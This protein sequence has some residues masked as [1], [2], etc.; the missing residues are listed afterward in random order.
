[1]SE[2]LR[3]KSMKVSNVKGITEVDLALDES[4]TLLTGLNGAGTT[5]VIQALV[6]AVTSTWREKPSARRYPLF[7]FPANVLRTGTSA[8]DIELEVAFAGRPPI[9]TGHT[10]RERDLQMHT[11]SGHEASEYLKNPPGP[12]PLVVY[13]E[14][15]RW[16]KGD[17]RDNHD[18]SLSAKTNRETAL[19]AT[20]SALR[21]LKRWF[22]EKEAKEQRDAR[23]RQ[24]P[25]YEDPEL[26]TI[27]GLLTQLD[28]FTAIRSRNKTDSERLMLVVEKEGIDIPFDS[29][30]G[31]EEA[32]FVLSADL[33]RRLMMEFPNTEVCEAPG[34]VCIDKIE[35]HLHPAWERKILPSLMKT[36]PACQFVISSHSPQ[37]LASV[38]AQHIRILETAKNGVRSV[39]QPIASK[40]RDS[41]YILEAVLGTPERNDDVSRLLAKCDQL[42]DA[43]ELDA[44]ET[45]LSTLNESVEGSAAT[46]AIRRAKVNRLRRD[47]K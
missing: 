37:V 2:L 28:G 16:A 42:I 9:A 46:I 21:E 23:E 33:A 47:T 29:L 4:L 12:L 30:S 45:V 31:G 3:V 34:L 27:R 38:E 8:M 1:M 20:D 26:K 11:T 25:R 22:F 35:Q 13:Y 36:F 40:G 39:S 41:N 44:A 15:N 24:D 18:V 6:G 14:Q 43:Y 19:D 32:V 17:D 10:L 5:S 7:W